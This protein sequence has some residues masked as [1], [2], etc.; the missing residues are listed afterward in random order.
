MTTVEY[1]QRRHRQKKGNKCCL[2][3]IFCT[4][5]YCIGIY[6]LLQQLNIET[7]DIKIYKNDCCQY[8]TIRYRSICNDVFVKHYQ[9]DMDEITFERCNN[10]PSEHALGIIF[11]IS[12]I[13]F[14]IFGFTVIYM[15]SFLC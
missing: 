13:Y 7:N 3:F 10:I 4:I 15:C 12:T 6:F 1:Y 2:F 5:G 8:E 9:N 11:G 14:L